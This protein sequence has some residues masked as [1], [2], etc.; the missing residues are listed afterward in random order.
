[1]SIHVAR[2]GETLAAIAGIYKV[3]LWLLTQLN[4]LEAQTPLISGQTILILYPTQIHT[5]E[6]GDT[7][8]GIA[9]RYGLSL[10]QLLRNNPGLITKTYIYPGEPVVIRYEHEPTVP[11]IISGYAYPFIDISLFMQTLPYVTIFNSFTYEITGDGHLSALSDELL[12]SLARQFG[13]RPHMVIS[14]LVEPY[15]FDPQRAHLILGSRRMWE[16]FIDEILSV[17]TAKGYAGVDVDFEYVPLEDREHFPE[18]MVMLHR[19]L[20]QEGR[21]L[22]AALS[23]KT[24]DDAPGQLVEG[25]DYRALG[26]AADAILLMTY[27]WGYAAG[28]PMAVAPLPEVKKVLDY[29][30]TRIPPEKILLGIPNYGYDWPLATDSVGQRVRATSLSNIQAVD[31]ARSTGSAILYDDLSQAPWFSYIQN[32]IEHVVWFE[33]A[34]SIQAK[35]SLIAQYKLKGAGYWNLMRPFPQNWPLLNSL[36]KIL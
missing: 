9:G 1:M 25:L 6:A 22:T 29:A 3:P 23:A 18:F 30:V 4:G 16:P 27:E 8:Y 26:A 33:D 2:Q 21:M 36:Y 20:A 31:L 11:A 19:R 13:T 15:G 28:E 34:R 35:L 10:R 32:G 5:V 7:L 17:V 12:I 14:N 24:R